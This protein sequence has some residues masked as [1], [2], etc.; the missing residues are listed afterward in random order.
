MAL[1][2]KEIKKYHFYPS[3]RARVFA[4]HDAIIDLKSNTKIAAIEPIQPYIPRYYFK[5]IDYANIITNSK[6]SRIL[7]GLPSTSFI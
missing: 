1:P 7:T 2:I 6:G 3:L 5:F 4:A